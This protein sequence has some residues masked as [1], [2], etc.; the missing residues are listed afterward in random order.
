[1]SKSNSHLGGVIRS[2]LGKADRKIIL[3]LGIPSIGKTRCPQ[4]AP[5]PKI[6]NLN[7]ARFSPPVNQPN[8]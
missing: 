6:R 1:M 8:F 4:K 2:H 5:S 3:L 7:R